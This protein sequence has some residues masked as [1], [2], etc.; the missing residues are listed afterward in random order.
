[1]SEQTNLAEKS[2]GK[3]VS[4]WKRQKSSINWVNEI[5]ERYRISKD[6]SKTRRDQQLELYKLYH[7]YVDASQKKKGKA[8][9][10]LHK[11]FPQIESETARYLASYMQHDPF[12][13]VV[14]TGSAFVEKAKAREEVMQYYLEHCPNH[15]FESLRHIKFSLMFG[16]GYKMPTWRRT[17]EQVR[18]TVPISVMGQ[19]VGET[20][21]ETPEV[22]YDGLWFHSFSPAEVFPFPWARSI[23][24]VPWVIVE[25]FVHISE[26]I[27]RAEMGGFDM[28]KVNKIPLNCDGQQDAEYRLKM[29][30][31]GYET[32]EN[33]PEIIRL[34]HM[35]S[36][37][38]IMT[39]ANGEI[40]IREVPMIFWHRRIPLVMGVKTID[41][42]SYY[43]IG[44]IK[45][46]VANQKAVNLAI[47]A[48]ANTSVMSQWWMWKFRQGKVDPR[49]L[50][51][52]PN[53]RIPV[54]SMDDVEIIQ[55]P[56]VKQ[57]M[58]LFKSLIEANIEEVS[59]YYGPQKGYSQ[60]RHT[61]TSDMIFEQQG[62]KRIQADVMTFENLGLVPEAEMCAMLIE[63][64]MPPGTEV[65]LNGP[66]GVS[67]AARSP[68]DIRGEFEYQ[69]GG[70]SESIR[71]SVAQQQYIE[72]FGLANQATQYVQLPSGQII[73]VPVLDTYNALKMMYE[74]AAGKATDRVLYRPEIFGQPLS[75]DLLSQYGL[76]AI[77]GV[78]NLPLNPATGG[79]GRSPQGSLSPNDISRGVRPDQ[80]INHP[81]RRAPQPLLGVT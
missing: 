18:R 63:Q 61:A 39:L 22:I 64:F 56:E 80:I 55:P 7:G 46:L 32:P 41:P 76:P 51:P 14:P 36:T 45:P 8:N 74:P 31:L 2:H 17:I 19:Q 21:I 3:T 43:P 72:L 9:F 59:G 57:D 67:F 35:F 37:D 28:D 42:E 52:I 29:Q 69:V 24:Q 81:A 71:R 20:E 78:D 12:V 54:N 60:Q 26:V 49:Y 75:N 23:G 15:F 70:I 25:E 5:K 4:D 62:D 6:A 30:A 58:L 66:G 27:K 79:R 34:Q 77:P 68:E 10:H 53:G 38:S 40:L 13:T 65:R 1:M 50:L 48:I 47:N 73:P 16:Y 44:T 11:I 33:N